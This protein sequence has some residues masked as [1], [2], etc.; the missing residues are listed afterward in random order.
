MQGF[1]PAARAVAHEV[2]ATGGGVP[3]SSPGPFPDLF[4]ADDQPERA[5]DRPG[6]GLVHVLHLD[7][8]RLEAKLILVGHDVNATI[9]SLGRQPGTVAHGPEQMRHEVSEGVT[10]QFLRQ[11][12]QDEVA[13]RV[14]DFLGDQ[15]HRLIFGDRSGRSVAFRGSPELTRTVANLKQTHR[16]ADLVERALGE[17]RPGDR[18]EPLHRSLVGIAG[19]GFRGVLAEVAQ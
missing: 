9:W 7:D 18:A 19:L 4:R 14:L 15:R 5:P 13:G 12:L 3:L 10:L 1:Q 16:R 6:E 8:K 17:L 2:R 11:R